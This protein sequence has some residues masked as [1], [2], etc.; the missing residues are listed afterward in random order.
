MK[1][2][3]SLP[4]P[5]S[6]N[7][8]SWKRFSVHLRLIWSSLHEHGYEVPWMWHF[9]ELQPLCHSRR[10]LTH[11]P[12]PFPPDKSALQRYAVQ[13]FL[14]FFTPF[15]DLHPLHISPIFPPC[16]S[17][18]FRNNFKSLF[19]P[20]PSYLSLDL[21]HIEHASSKVSD[22]LRARA[23]RKKGEFS[24]KKLRRCFRNC[25]PN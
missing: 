10:F 18:P 15:C 13:L 9:F 5:K 17:N 2:K 6:S 16:P 1:A 23:R 12:R 21:S 3:T 8:P 20:L 19:V 14:Q 22:A 11:F 7:H 24:V 25:A 4:Y